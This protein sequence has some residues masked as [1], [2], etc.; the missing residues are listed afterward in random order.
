MPTVQEL[1]QPIPQ[2]HQLVS[3]RVEVFFHSSIQYD[4]TIMRWE[5]EWAGTEACGSHDMTVPIQ[6][7]V[8]L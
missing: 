4:H 1:L 8:R 6:I 7:E 2:E 3:G 5:H